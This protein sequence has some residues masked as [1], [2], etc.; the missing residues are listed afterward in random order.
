[1]YLTY[2]ARTDCWI[3]LHVLT[4]ISFGPNYA[5]RTHAED[6]C[7]MR[8]QRNGAM[9][10]LADD[11]AFW[12]LLLHCLLDKKAIAARH[13]ARLHELV[14]AASTG[15]PLAKLVDSVCP[16]G[17]SAVRLIECVR[18]ADWSTLER[19]GPRLKAEWIRQQPLGLRLKMLGGTGLRLMARL[20]SRLQRRGLSIA[21]LGPDGA[22]KSTLAA[23]VGR[24]FFSPVRSVHMALSDEHLPTFARLRVPGVGSP[25]LLL[26]VWWRYA[27]SLYHRALGRLVIFDRYV[28]LP[29]PRQHSFIKRAKRWLREHSCPTP[30]LVIVLD[31]PAELMYKRKGELTPAQLEADRQHLLSLTRQVARAQVIDATAPPDVIRR[32]VVDRVW[33]LYADR[34][35]NRQTQYLEAAQAR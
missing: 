20:R 16:P 31:A 8:R 25:G 28:Y 23:G 26:V 12:V 14:G 21:V 18:Q 5:L 10:T 4:E 6:G 15:G 34:W 35:T 19:L 32:D 33:K 13:R 11:D 1:M 30:D 27:I 29:P 3:W 22:G 7:L 24:S 2:D 17:W 9:V